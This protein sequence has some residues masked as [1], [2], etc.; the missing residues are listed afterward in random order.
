MAASKGKGVQQP[1]A[2]VAIILMHSRIASIRFSLRGADLLSVQQSAQCQQHL[3]SCLPAL[4][5][6]PE[7]GQREVCKPQ[8]P[9]HMPLNRSA[10]NKLG[11]QT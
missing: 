6:L 7:G 3:E 11:G 8:L 10:F 1:P 5:C 9:W 4:L 2:Q